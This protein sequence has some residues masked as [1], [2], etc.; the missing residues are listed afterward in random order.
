MVFCERDAIDR[1]P[2]DILNDRERVWL[3]IVLNLDLA[4]GERPATFGASN[5]FRK[6]A[7]TCGSGFG[8]NV[9]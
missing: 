1:Q 2:L 3:G 7:S 6:Y 8:V 4:L 5:R 9:R